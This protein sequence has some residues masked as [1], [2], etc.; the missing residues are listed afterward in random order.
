MKQKLN[1][2]IAL[3]TGG[4]K[5]LGAAI[6]RS[7]A[8]RGFTVAVHYNSA[9]QEA[10]ELCRSIR[11]QGG[12]AAPFQADL[13]QDDPADFIEGIAAQLGPISLLVNNA[14]LFRQ[15]SF[16]GSDK[17]LWAEHFKI[18]LEVPVFLA[19]AVARTYPRRKAAKGKKTA[20]PGAGLPASGLII[21]MVDERV[22]RLNPHFFSYTLSKAA[23]WTA[24]QTMAQA[25]APHFRVNA[26]GPGPSLK[27]MRQSAADFAAQCASLPMQAGPQL[28]DFGK[29]VLYL[30]DTPA[31]TGQLIALDGG[32]HLMWQTP[33]LQFDLGG[34]KA[35]KS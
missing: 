25:L 21:N 26:I 20:A 15:D 9:A 14:S 12:K 11:A 24:T 5:R 4:A 27:N 10:A 29:T 28:A 17:K 1:Q 7:L 32:Q 3:V 6:S 31:I 34:D 22:L 23:L 18:H 13:L 16:T 19:Q 8:A 35:D 30:W 2:P 33:D